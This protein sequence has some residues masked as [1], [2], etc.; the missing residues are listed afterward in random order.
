MMEGP[1]L[2]SI[3][4]L[5][6]LIYLGDLNNAVFSLIYFGD[7]TVFTVSP[8]FRAFQVPI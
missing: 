5:F 8:V 3:S 2:L 6:M 7:I 4:L 1:G